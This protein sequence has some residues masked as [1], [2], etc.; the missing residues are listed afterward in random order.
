MSLP[1]T[2]AAQKLLF[3]ART[4]ATEV[5]GIDALKH[6]RSKKDIPQID[7]RSGNKKQG[8]PVSTFLDVVGDPTP[9]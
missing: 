3:R 5:Y 6:H 8:N 2:G 7:T 1:I 9:R 4:I